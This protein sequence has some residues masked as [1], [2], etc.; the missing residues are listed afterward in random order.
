[1]TSVARRLYEEALTLPDG[2]RADL[3]ARLFE[4]LDSEAERDVDS[5]W[6]A[7]IARR[8]K[9]LDAG[10]VRPVPW[11]EAEDMIFGDLGDA[12]TSP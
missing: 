9:A 3:A 6:S 2:D 10:S 7:E 1:M 11:E 4:S 8:L 5:A 12:Q